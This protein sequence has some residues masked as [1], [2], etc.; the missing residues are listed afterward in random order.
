MFADTK[1]ELEETSK[2]LEE[3]GK[4]LENTTDNLR[5]T[6]G[7]LHKMTEDRDEQKHLVGVHVNTERKLHSQATQ[8]YLIV[9][10]AFPILFGTEL[11]KYV[12]RPLCIF[13]W[14]SAVVAGQ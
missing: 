3:T 6:T 14:Y 12:C 4:K 11:F 7:K 9:H 1:R 13:F 8:V 10:T 2:E 5:V